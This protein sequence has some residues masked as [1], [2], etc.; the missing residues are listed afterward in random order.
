MNMLG[1]IAPGRKGYPWRGPAH[2]FVLP[3]FGTRISNTVLVRDLSSANLS[4]SLGLGPVSWL[5][6]PPSLKC[7][8]VS[9]QGSV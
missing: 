5:F 8:V 9:P 4:I 7:L 3:I 1:A 2:I 6:I